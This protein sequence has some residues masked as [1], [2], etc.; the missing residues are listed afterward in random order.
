[1]I[2]ADK[3]AV[4]SKHAKTVEKQRPLKPSSRKPVGIV[5]RRGALRRSTDSL[6]RP[7]IFL[8]S[9]RGTGDK[10]IDERPLGRLRT[11]TNARLTDARSHLYLGGC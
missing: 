9:S 7:W 6:E 11:L 3:S 10:A 5:V 1:M 8:S 2:T 4:P